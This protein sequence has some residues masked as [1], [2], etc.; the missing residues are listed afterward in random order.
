MA[1]MGYT[2][3]RGRFPHSPTKTATIFR[4]IVFFADPVSTISVVSGDKQHGS[5]TAVLPNPF[6]VLVR[7][8]NNNPLPNASVTFAI[9]SGTG[10]LSNTTVLTDA[11][12]R[13]S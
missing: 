9:T 11:T 1:T 12:G 2:A 3:V 7:D 8:A 10:S 13:A 4:E 5:G 6:T